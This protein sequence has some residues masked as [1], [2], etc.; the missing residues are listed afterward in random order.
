V[1]VTANPVAG[2]VTTPSEATWMSA[3]T[4]DVS[5]LSN[6]GYTFNSWSNTAQITVSSPSSTTTTATVSGPGTITANF[7]QTYTTIYAETSNGK[8]KELTLYG[9]ISASQLT[10][11]K[12][13][14]S[15]LSL[16]TKISFSA[17]G[18]SGT[19]GFSNITI[20]KSSV[21]YGTKPTVYI[22]GVK[23]EN[24][25]Y[26]QDSENFYVWFTTHFSEHEISIDFLSDDVSPTTTPTTPDEPS[27]PVL[28]V[29]I[30]VAVIIAL[31]ALGLF[32]YKRRKP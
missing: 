20:A 18:P 29:V 16:S 13:T 25:G 28:L 5:V 12:I 23:A 32:V 30:A 21:A 15:P 22:D 2:G 26:T 17:T 4:L 3:G 9:N 7:N 6:T 27:N 8:T 10:N 1:I 14:P 24:Q 31:V 19:V 11:A